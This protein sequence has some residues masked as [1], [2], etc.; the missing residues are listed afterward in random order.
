MTRSS[1]DIPARLDRLPWARFHRLVIFAL[2]VTW[3]LD[4]LEVTLV[5]SFAPALA[6]SPVLRLS[7]RGVGLT[8]SAYLVGAVL[9]SILF[10]YLA[11]RFGR[12]RLFT[13]TLGLYIS[14][15]ALSGI[16]WSFGSF[17]VFRFLTGAGIGGEYSAINSA[18]QEMIPAARRGRVDLVVNG[19]FWLGAA[20]ASGLAIWLLRPGMLPAD[21]GWRV[22]FGL[23]ALLGLTALWMRRYVPE[24]P[25]WLMVRGR[26]EE[27]DQIVRSIEHKVMVEQ[28][29]NR[30]AQ[31]PVTRTHLQEPY[32]V[33][34]TTALKVIFRR[35][36]KRAFLGIVLMATQAFFYNA[37]FFTYGLVLAR[38]YHEPA[39]SVGLYL[40]PFA[41][42]NFLG[43]VLL[44]RLFDTIGRRPMMTATYALSGVLM[45]LS[46]LA[47]R[48]RMLDGLTQTL[49][50][51]GMFFFASAGASGAYLTVGES[52]PLEIRASAI[53]WFYAFGT[54]SGGAFAPTLFGI[55]IHTGSRDRVFAGYLLGAALM[56]IG[57][58]TEALFGIA[59]ERKPLED[60]ATPLSA[61]PPEA[62]GSARSIGPQL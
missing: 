1:S 43:A 27:A 3:I 15:T 40:L 22:G 2:G 21:M 24:S 60:I 62:S 14:A 4:G 11:D 16:A 55:L 28:G 23:G 49:V 31:I 9:G 38:F 7:A 12:K 37:F 42:S 51:S 33:G 46:A 30:L 57:A 18:I 26:H 35:Y 61:L 58:V 36:P 8:A 19:S 45:I 53:A 34:F 52:F 50:W 17:S 56:M 29:L 32:R 41:L 59:A 10:G 48:A 25:R 13:A 54:L 5:G 44:A 20:V 6:H 47:F 39:D